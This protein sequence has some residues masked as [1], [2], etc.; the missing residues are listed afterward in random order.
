[1]TDTCADT[2]QLALPFPE[3]E[4][5]GRP[6]THQGRFELFQTDQPAIFERFVELAD[7]AHRAGVTRVSAKY[8][9]ERIRAETRVRIDN[10]HTSRFVRALR[11]CRPDLAELFVMRRI[12][13]P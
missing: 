6:T 12:R 3:P 5:T 1:M 7:D 10:S 13:T 8:L 4:P 9:I 2:R 11:E